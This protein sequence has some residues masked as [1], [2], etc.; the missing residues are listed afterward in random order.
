MALSLE[1]IRRTAVLMRRQ[2][3][4]MAA[5]GKTSH[6][7]SALSCVEILAVLYFKIMNITANNWKSAQADRFILSKGHGAKA[8]YA[9]LAQ[10]GF[11]PQE[12]LE[13]YA[14]DGH[15]LGEHPSH[16]GVPGIVLSTGSLGH[17]LSV[18]SGMALARKMDGLTSKVFVVLSDG[19]C[20]EGSVWEAAMCAA[21]QNLDNLIV[22]VDDNG[23]QALGRS[24]EVNALEPFQDKWAAFGWETAQ[25]DGHDLEALAQVLSQ[26]AARPGKPKVVIARTCLGRGVS[27]MEDDLLWHY[28]IPSME[29]W[30][31]AMEEL[32]IS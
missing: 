8:W 11:F 10:A 4:T 7:G 22:V 18:A 30:H 31:R 19:E 20:N 27:F 26:M 16:D 2:I 25:V 32:K 15:H 24:R 13:H 23:W 6:V 3:V 12:W 5:H 9:A 28:Q 17:G 1:D 29:Q 14:V 21:H